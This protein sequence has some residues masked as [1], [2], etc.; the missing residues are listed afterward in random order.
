MSDKRLNEFF[1]GLQRAASSSPSKLAGLSLADLLA[2][3]EHYRVKTLR[4]ST[5]PD[6]DRFCAIKAEIDE[7]IEE[8]FTQ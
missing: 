8:L 4:G 2:L 5:G 1:N 3:A 7:R 6:S